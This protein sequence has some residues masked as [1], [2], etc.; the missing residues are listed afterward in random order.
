M[1]KLSDGLMDNVKG[2]QA[3]VR[4]R[5]LGDRE[6]SESAFWEVESIAENVPRTRKSAGGSSNRLWW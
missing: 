6:Q 5:G 4:E 1:E 3:M 2:Y